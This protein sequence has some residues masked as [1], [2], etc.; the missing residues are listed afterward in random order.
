MGV[1]KINYGSRTVMDL[2]KDTVTASK[3]LKG[4]TAHDKKGNQITGTYEAGTSG[5]GTNTSDATAVASNILE[6]KDRLYSIW[7]NNRNDDEQ[8]RY[9]W[10]DI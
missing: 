2:S 5:G 10:H 9:S 4:V 1:S 3:L 8:R 6:K 7:K